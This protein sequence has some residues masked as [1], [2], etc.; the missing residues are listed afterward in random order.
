MI[1]TGDC[2]CDHANKEF[3][4]LIIT[5]QRLPIALSYHQITEL[6]LS[7]LQ[8]TLIDAFPFE[9]FPKLHS[10]D[11]SHNQLTF[12]NADWSKFS[13]HVVE[14]LNLSYNY[15]DTLLCLKDFKYLKQVNITENR[16]R[17]HERCLSFYLCSTLECMIDK[18]TD[19]SDGD[20]LQL[21]RLLQATETNVDRLWSM[22]YRQRYMQGPQDAQLREQ[23][24]K[25][26]HQSIMTIMEDQHE[27]FQ[28]HLSPIANHLVRSTIEQVCSPT[29]DL[30]SKAS[31]KTDLADEFHLSIGPSF[32]PVQFLRCHHQSDDD[33][34]TVPV[35]ACAFEPNAVEEYPRDMR[36]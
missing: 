7:N 17:P 11:L 22:S 21:D 33:L 35:R 4:S 6:N 8:L 29:A 28:F 20:R 14:D 27:F 19:Q 15:L 13:N 31:S 26:M 2:Q 30:Q 12:I 34:T 23:L 5:A 18:Q 3:L 16:L 10:L 1:S 24:T 9:C 25:E 36:W 32:R